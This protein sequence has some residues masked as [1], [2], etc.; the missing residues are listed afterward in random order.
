MREPPPSIAAAVLILVFTASGALAENP[1]LEAYRDSIQDRVK[2]LRRMVRK[3]DNPDSIRFTLAT[4]LRDARSLEGRLEA[5]RIL[6]DLR[7]RHGTDSR[8]ALTLANVY[9]DSRRLRDAR[10]TLLRYARNDSTNVAARVLAARLLVKDMLHYSDREHLTAASALLDQAH[11]LAPEHDDALYLA[12]VLQYIARRD[13]PDRVARSREGRRRAEQIVARRPDDA[14]ACLLAGVHCMD[15]GSPTDAEHWFQRG[16]SY[17][18]PDAA[19]DFLIPPPLLARVR[20]EGID[21]Q[22]RL[23]T[24]YWDGQDPTP[25]TLVNETQLRYWYNMT[26]ADLYYAEPEKGVHGWQTAPG[27]SIVLFGPPLRA[28]FDPGT[29]T[30]GGGVVIFDPPRL[31][32]T[33]E[34]GLTL[35]FEDA[36]LQWK[37]RGTKGTDH[38][39]AEISKLGVATAA[40]IHPGAAPRIYVA[41]AGARGEGAGA[42]EGCVIAIPPWSDHPRWWSETTG[43]LRVVDPAYREVARTDFAADST[44]LREMAHHRACLVLGSDFDLA[45]G[46]YTLLVD[47]STPRGTGIWGDAGKGTVRVP[48]DVRAFE[49]GTLQLSDLELARTG[50]FKERA[51]VLRQPRRA[52]LPNP[53]GVV[54]PEGSVDIAYSVYDLARDRNGACRYE[55]DYMIVPIAYRRA[56]ERKLVSGAATPEDSLEFGRQ[57]HRLG[58]VTL[59]ERN[60]Q[61]VHFSPAEVNRAGVRPDIRKMATLNLG[62]M[63]EGAYVLRVVVTDK[64]SGQSARAETVV[65]KVTAAQPDSMLAAP[66][67]NGSA[68]PDGED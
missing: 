43:S 3:S 8:V 17:L 44:D 35:T 67:K 16:I 22:K 54:G 1:R 57:G 14:Q 63:E 40:P 11:A 31:A 38:L 36:L 2:V 19:A 12:S 53:L 55:L 61:E 46:S 33:Y 60:R 9:L 24:A 41:H 26:I 66:R 64:I 27:K 21:E 56:Y 32:M 18:P 59:S 51:T 47:V 5:V 15:L 13:D 62:G 10:D 23:I 50:T 28:S 37:W 48:L 58:D 42:R 45:P 7:R 68:A 52:F 30:A 49:A 20:L 6:E 4:T 65:R 29:V 34:T 39:L 25:L